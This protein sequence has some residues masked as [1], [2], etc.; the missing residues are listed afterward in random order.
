MR[1]RGEVEFR[2]Q[3]SNP[4]KTSPGSRSLIIDKGYHS[5]MMNFNCTFDLIE[6]LGSKASAGYC[7]KYPAAFWTFYEREESRHRASH[8]GELHR[9]VPSDL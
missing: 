3:E 5:K 9:G 4:S 2:A 8:E 1:G 6:R 7:G